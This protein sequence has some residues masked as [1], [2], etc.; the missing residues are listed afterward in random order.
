MEFVPLAL[1]L[2][3]SAVISG[4]ET[5]VFSLSR[6]QHDALASRS[7]AAAALLHRPTKLLIS[8]LLANLI[9]NVAYFSVSASWSL[10][11]AQSTTGADSVAV[12][13]G[14]VAG[15]VLFGEILPKTM[16]LGR[17]AKFVGWASP[18]LLGLRWLLAPVVFVGEGASRLL[19]RLVLGKSRRPAVPDAVDFKS[20]LSSRAAVGA[21]RSV[22][23]ALL[24]DVID[25]GRRRARH[26]MI[27]RTEVVF[28]DITDDRSVWADRM[29]ENPFVEYPVCEGGADTLLGTINTARLMASPKASRRELVEEPLCVPVNLSAE[30][31]VEQMSEHEVRL[32]I[33]LDEWGGVAGIVGLGALT[34]AVLGE[35]ERQISSTEGGGLVR[36]GGGALVPGDCPLHILEEELGLS[37][38]TRRSDTVGGAMAEVLG[39]V[40]VRGEEVQ[41]GGFRWR[42]VD[43]SRGRVRRVMLRPLPSH[44]DA[45]SKEALGS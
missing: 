16:A 18:L 22:E 20:A 41:I 28:L 1:L 43:G 37:I 36:R 27:P 42:V 32:A 21:Y 4:S 45:V 9:V 2:L 6:V 19:E 15:M 5:A 35:V 23:L 8:L 17:A 14:S 24:H 10:R 12:A 38:K 33:L 13:L 3:L 11:L 30:R 39:A 40:P 34:R 26:L 44:G 31:L 7:R 29:G 25:F